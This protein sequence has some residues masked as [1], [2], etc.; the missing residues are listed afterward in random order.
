MAER[1]ITVHAGRDDAGLRLDVF[2]SRRVP[3]LS[4]SRAASVVDASG[5][6]VDGRIAKSSYRM[7]G[8]ESIDVVVPEPAPARAEA[9][10][11]P[12]DIVY[13]D[14]DIVA[15]NK[16]PGLVVHPAAGNPDGTLVNALLAHSRDLSGIGGVMRPGI[17]HRLDK[18][19]SGVIV[20]AKNDAAHEALTRQFASRTLTKVY[21]AITIGAPS[22]RAGVVDRPIGRHTVD[23]KRM[24][25]D[26]PRSRAA[27]TEYET[28]AAAG[29]LAV[30]RCGLLT[31]RTHQIRVHLQSLR[32]PI[33][34][35]AVYG[36]RNAEK[37]LDQMSMSD[38]RAMRRPALHAWRIEFDHPRDG[39]R[40]KLEA[41][42]PSDMKCILDRI[43]WTP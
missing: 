43:G 18:G 32:C 38:A 1:R 33:L 41:A 19:T 29:G 2:L 5:V 13:E 17:V 11:I 4:R 3:A 26:V 36:G 40:V 22:P 7:R 23:R 30:V 39:R 20:C 21:L 27:K 16:P 8:D 12:L 42:I 24:A 9:Q 34:G 25:V 14:A 10:A 31:G 37:R 15:V 6:T 35:D 28:L